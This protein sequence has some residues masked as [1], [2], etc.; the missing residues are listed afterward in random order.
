MGFLLKD[1]VFANFQKRII[2]IDKFTVAINVIGLSG[3]Y[4]SAYQ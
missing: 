1:M 3:L 2:I 4:D